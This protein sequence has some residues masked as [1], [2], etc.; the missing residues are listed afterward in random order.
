[1]LSH[2]GV[3]IAGELGVERGVFAAACWGPRGGD[4]G[5]GRLLVFIN[6]SSVRRDSSI[7]SRLQK[8]EYCSVTSCSLSLINTTEMRQRG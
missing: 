6:S 8:H 2:T 3:L 4:G 1:M 7:L 5:W